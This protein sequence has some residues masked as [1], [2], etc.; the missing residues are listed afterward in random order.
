MEM[1][2]GSFN[3]LELVS[4]KTTYKGTGLTD[5]DLARPIIGIAC[6]YNE[7]VPGHVNLRELCTSV[8]NGIYRA[9]GTPI[10]FGV[11]ACCDGVSDNH[12]GS[13]YVLPSR[14]II[15]DTVEAQCRAH[16]FD[17]LV[18]LGSCDKIVPGMLMGAARLNIPAI[19]VA[20][21]P[22]VSSPPFREKKKSNSTT[23]LRLTDSSPRA[24]SPRKSSSSSPLPA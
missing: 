18:M 1:K 14:D 5:D 7:A 23:I 15:A 12:Y 17:G 13:H 22:T 8:K 20:G 3:S 9:G 10:E 19:F 6:S 11:M 24:R 4:N 16:A 21:G 2:I